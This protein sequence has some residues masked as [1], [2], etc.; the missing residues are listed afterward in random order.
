MQQVT[1][2]HYVAAWP[3]LEHVVLG[4]LSCTGNMRGGA[5]WCGNWQDAAACKPV[6]AFG[7]CQEEYWLQSK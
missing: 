3:G 7:G 6:S 1:N 2:N 4:A 5:W